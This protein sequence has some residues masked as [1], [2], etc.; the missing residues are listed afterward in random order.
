[1]LSVHAGTV[2]R[3]LQRL[4]S[5]W[6][7]VVR[8]A[9]NELSYVDAQAFQDIYGRR[10]GGLYPFPKDPN[11][12][13]RAPNGV[14]YLSTA[15]DEIHPHMRHLISRSF[16]DRAVQEQEAIVQGHTRKFLKIITSL[17]SE[18]HCTMEIGC[19][20]SWLTFDILTDLGF[21]ESL[22]CLE[23]SMYRDLVNLLFMLPK[24]GVLSANMNS[25][26]I[27]KPLL[28]FVLPA[29]ILAKSQRLWEIA[30]AQVRKRLEI[31]TVDRPDIMSYLMPSPT[32]SGLTLP[33][34][35]ATGFLLMFAGAETTGS[36]L[37]AAVSY[38]VR[39][40][41]ALHNLQC[42][43]ERSYGS[44]AD[45]SFTNSTQ[46]PYLNAVIREALRL[47]PPVPGNLARVVPLGGGTVCGELLP[48][49]V[50]PNLCPCF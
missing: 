40:P 31:S 18:S 2:H 3:D 9:P 4:H 10:K 25:V 17:T 29:D 46:L 34:L 27:L 39:S 38:L 30:V 23:S 37:C 11:F 47:A 44:T 5:V 13:E 26:K 32:R 49:G 33:E 43:L 15:P 16:S 19:Y 6:G 36:L 28:L 20:I 42:E 24:A 50:S 1:M 21:G 14:H 45:I 8:V 41:R 7:P 22:H 12:Y 35:E 48:A